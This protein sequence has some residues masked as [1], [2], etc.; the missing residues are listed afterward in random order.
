M[1]VLLVED[2]AVVREGLAAV[3]EHSGAIS[4]AGQ[5]SSVRDGLRILEREAVDVVV[6]DLRLGDEHGVDLVREVR[7]R[8]DGPAILVLSAH[9]ATLELER[10]LGAGANGYLLKGSDAVTVTDAV[11]ETAAGRTVIDTGFVPK[12][13]HRA[14][15]MEDQPTPRELEVLRLCAE[16]AT[17][18]E[19]ARELGISPRTA[20][21]HI[22]RLFKK[23]GV[24]NRAELVSAA[25]R[26]GL[27]R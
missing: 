10:A 6:L 1:R 15:H 11:L 7:R 21:K 27:V 5:A 13:L 14:A 23:L 3:L 24:S 9:D 22:E 4:I 25:F 16:G 12:L 19:I 8:E 2:H 26:R 18:V 17:A 20:Q